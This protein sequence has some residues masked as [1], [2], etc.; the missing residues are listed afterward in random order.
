MLTTTVGNII[1]KNS[2]FSFIDIQSFHEYKLIKL[3]YYKMSLYNNV[4][5]LG[6]T[7]YKF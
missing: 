5:D 2:S 7:N 3:I 1:R 4:H 6:N